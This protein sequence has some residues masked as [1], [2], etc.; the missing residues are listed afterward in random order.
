MACSKHFSLEHYF[1]QKRIDPKFTETDALCYEWI[2]L[3]TFITW[4]HWAEGFPSEYARAGFSYTFSRDKVICFSCH[5]TIENWRKGMNPLDEHKARSLDCEFIRGVTRGDIP[6]HGEFNRD[7][8]WTSP[9]VSIDSHD[10]VIKGRQSTD[11]CQESPA[12]Q[13]SLFAVKMKEGRHRQE[14]YRFWPKPEIVDPKSLSQSG[15]YFTGVGDI[16]KCAFCQGMLS[17]FQQGDVPNEMHLLR[18]P[19]CEFARERHRIQDLD[20]AI[21]QLSLTSSVQT[22]PAFPNFSTLESRLASF[23]DWPKTQTHPPVDM[24]SAGFFYAGISDCVKCHHCNGGLRNWLPGDDPWCEHAQWY[25][26]CSFL[27]KEQ[28][29]AL[30]AATSGRVLLDRK[31]SLST[32]APVTNRLS[33]NT[34]DRKH[35]PAVVQDASAACPTV[36]PHVDVSEAPRDI[37]SSKQE[38]ID[39]TDAERQEMMSLVEEN[40]ELMEKTMCKIC[41][42]EKCQLTFLPC[43]H[44]VTCLTCGPKLRKCPIC[45]ATIKGRVRIYMA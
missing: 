13:I 5:A 7:C 8:V 14:T 36:S 34:A 4:P 18:Y 35:R 6:I 12:D 17:G 37:G 2:R 43:G 3:K 15:L 9:G 25:P 29:Y 31:T 24:A 11:F 38:K 10:A 42:T 33:W 21:E 28:S 44:L 30:T 16:V 45:R 20:R 26:S 27:K 19:S 1:N 32:N 23:V 22:D 41:L 40:R 39:D